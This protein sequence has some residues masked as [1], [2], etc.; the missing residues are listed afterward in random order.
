MSNENKSQQIIYPPVVAVLGHV[1][2]G[3]TSLLDAIRS[4]SIAERESGGITQKIGA[5]SVEIMH[6]DKPRTIT[7]IDTPG[8]Q[9]FSQMR[10]RGAI[11]SDIGLLIVS[12]TDGVMPQTRESIEALKASKIPIIVVLTKADL[13]TKNIEKAKGQI[14]RE[15]IMLEGMGVTSLSWKY[16]QRLKATSKNC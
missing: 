8:H 2:H 5:S 1:D 15:G 16:P 12:S 11:A 9:A 10:S 14:L 7:F 4:T 13:P 3:K 6:D